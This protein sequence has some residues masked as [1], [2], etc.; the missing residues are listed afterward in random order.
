MNNIHEIIL[1]LL[2]AIL[3]TTG[4]GS[5]RKVSRE[6]KFKISGNGNVIA[7][8]GVSMSIADAAAIAKSKAN[9]ETHIVLIVS[10]EARFSD[11]VDTKKY[12]KEMGIPFGES[13]E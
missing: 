7:P 12:F 11:V 2:I 13:K 10:K 8:D 3:G 4:C 1:V 5:D 6:L 9:S